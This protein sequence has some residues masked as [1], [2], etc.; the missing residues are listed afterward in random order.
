MQPDC[1]RR[2]GSGDELASLGLDSVL[3]GAHNPQIQAK[4]GSEMSVRSCASLRVIL[5]IGLAQ[6]TGQLRGPARL[7]SVSGLPTALL[8][9][10]GRRLVHPRLRLVGVG[11]QTAMFCL[12]SFQ[13]V[14]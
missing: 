10:T 9:T 11:D 2:P 8:S 6:N 14:L 13:F 4:A 1:G 3:A 12:V 5:S 7:T